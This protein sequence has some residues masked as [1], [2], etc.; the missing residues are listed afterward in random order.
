MTTD[1]FILD[2]FP[3]ALQLNTLLISAKCEGINGQVPAG[4]T[5]RFQRDSH[6]V[7]LTL[8]KFYRNLP[9]RRKGE[10]DSFWFAAYS[11]WAAWNFHR[12]WQWTQQHWQLQYEAMRTQCTRKFVVFHN[13]PWM[14][15]GA[16][17]HLCA[18]RSTDC[19]L[20]G[21]NLTVRDSQLAGKKCLFLRPTQQNQPMCV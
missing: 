9:P 10:R 15:G 1:F 19:I 18:L 12:S 21:V 16:K 2:F 8:M 7:Q 17:S 11:S 5:T 14:H 20:Y 6:Q 13:I 4:E 3:A